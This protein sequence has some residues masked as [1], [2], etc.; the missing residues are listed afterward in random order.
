MNLVT[1]ATGILGSHVVLKLL[2]NNQ[3]V[4]ACKQKNSDLKKIEQLFSYYNEQDLFKKIS[5]KEVDV[6]DVFSIEEALEGVETVYHCAGFVSFNKKDRNELYKIN[7]NGTSNVL[8]ACMHKKISAFCHVSSVA[9][10]NNLDHKEPLDENVFWKTGGNES[11]YAL[12]KYNGE[13][14]VW[15]AMEEGMKALIVNPGVIL[16]PGF[17]DQSSSKLFG[18]CYAGNKYYTNGLAPYISA[19]DAAAIMIELIKKKQFANR[20]ILAEGNYSF[21]EIVDNIL[22]NFGKPKTF[23]NASRALLQIGRFFDFISSK[24]TGKEQLLS[25]AI[26]EAA[27]NKQTYLNTKLNTAL[28]YKYTPITEEIKEICRFFGQDRSVL[29]VKIL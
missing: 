11:D 2:Q 20:Y 13:R 25:A 10:I 17:W 7:E 21:K 19:K 6:C 5:W 29:G 24:I 3:P 27:F 15:R 12:S 1:G 9:T 22:T 16:S 28:H 23:I 14:E 18:R 26:V 8:A 4:V